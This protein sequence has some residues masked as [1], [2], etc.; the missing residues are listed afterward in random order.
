VIEDTTLV[1]E[2]ATISQVCGPAEVRVSAGAK[3]VNL[4]GKTIMLMIID[5]MCIL[6][7]L[8]TRSYGT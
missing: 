1:V 4:A 2:A 8:A 6:A 3:R 5:T 7:T